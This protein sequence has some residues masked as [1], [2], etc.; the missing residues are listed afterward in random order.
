MTQ[1]LV[2]Q[3][4]SVLTLNHRKEIRFEVNADNNNEQQN[5]D[6]ESTWNNDVGL[7]MR[8][9]SFECSDVER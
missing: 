6:D 3:A 5:K 7:C 2:R 8:R 4:E 9:L 1:R